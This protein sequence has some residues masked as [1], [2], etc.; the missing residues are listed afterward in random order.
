MHP[1]AAVGG[2]IISASVDID[3]LR[4]V[5][6]GL[7][8]RDASRSFKL[9]L[10]IY[11]IANIAMALANIALEPGNLWFYWPLIGW[12]LG[13]VSHYYFGVYKASSYMKRLFDEAL[14][15]LSR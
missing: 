6:V 8:L 10:S 13:V 4:R 11:I 3:R 15:E 5:L 7:Y 1:A 2:G 9:H 12:G 14:E